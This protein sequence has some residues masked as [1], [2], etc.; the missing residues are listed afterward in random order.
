VCTQYDVIIVGAG[1][2]GSYAGYHLAKAGLQVLIIE[3]TAF[4]RE[5]LC[6]GGVSLTAAR[7]LKGVINLEALPHI[8][9]SGSYLSYRNEHLT[10]VRQSVTS[11]S[12]NRRD[13]DDAILKA[14]TSAGCNVLMPAEVIDAQEHA[15][16]VD[17]IIRGCAPVKSAFLVLASGANGRLYRNLSYLGERETTMALKVDVTPRDVPAGLKE[18]TL[19]DFGAI[20]SGYAWIFP[21]NGF[22]NVGAYWYRSQTIGRS[23]IQAL[24]RFIRQFDWGREGKLGPLKGFPIPRTVSFQQF[25]T[26]RSL[27]VGDAAGAIENLYGEGL[28]YGFESSCIAAEAIIDAIRRNRSLKVYTA[29]LKS[30]ILRQMMFS[31]ITAGQFYRRQRLGYYRM[32]RNRW[33]NA[34]YAKLIHG[35]V[36]PRRALFQSLAVL[37]VSF[38]SGKLPRAPFEE[39]GM[40]SRKE[41]L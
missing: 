30:E 8:V 31:R 38:L 12:V 39:V 36:T 5:K 2:A 23:Q 22:F 20:P 35:L 37:P 3:K 18:N 27:I 10:Y 13:L 4:P 17:V 16:G 34:I 40:V 41:A 29:R 6:G 21:K 26:A 7:L 28:A 1:P 9:P 33:L 14:A 24:Q 11:Y 19:F 15:D 25:N 32:V